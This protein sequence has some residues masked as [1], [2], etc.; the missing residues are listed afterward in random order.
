MEIVKKLI[1]PD[2]ADMLIEAHGPE[3]HHLT[4]GIGI[5]F[6]EIL[7]EAAL[8][9]RQRRN[10]LQRVFLNERGKAIEIAGLH[11]GGARNA[12]GVCFERMIR[13]EP[14]ADVDGAF[15]KAGVLTDEILVHPARR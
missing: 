15:D 14:V 13:A 4:F 11:G 5:E 1:S 10:L 3:R 12:F 2:A 9:A 7:Q 6:C 8:Y